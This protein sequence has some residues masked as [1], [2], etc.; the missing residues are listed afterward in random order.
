[1]CISCFH[2]RIIQNHVRHYECLKLP[3]FNLSLNPANLSHISI[4]ST[5]VLCATAPEY[6]LVDPTS[7][8]L[9]DP[10]RS[11][12]RTASYNMNEH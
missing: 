11:F 5:P 2:L 7:S 8:Q 9:V 4:M 12:R 6:S 3:D 1:M 10:C